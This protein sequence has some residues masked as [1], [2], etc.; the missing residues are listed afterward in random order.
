M[1]MSFTAFL[2]RDETEAKLQFLGKSN[3]CLANSC[4]WFGFA[5]MSHKLK[6]PA[7]CLHFVFSHVV[8]LK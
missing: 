4:I 6:V 2:P 5:L 1:Q 3:Q 7:L 8:I